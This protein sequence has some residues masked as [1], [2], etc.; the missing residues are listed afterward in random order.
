MVFEDG[1]VTVDGGDMAVDGGSGITGWLTVKGAT[2][3]PSSTSGS[4]RF[5]FICEG[6]DEYGRI[7]I[8]V[9][10]VSFMPASYPA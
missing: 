5:A 3:A 2:V 8:G 7:A 10:Q 6:F 4:L 9:D 1:T